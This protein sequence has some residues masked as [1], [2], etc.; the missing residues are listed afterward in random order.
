[1]SEPISF[2]YDAQFELDF[3][4]LGQGDNYAQLDHEFD[5]E[6]GKKKEH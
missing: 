4:P 3:F 6:N 2:T 5:G 1:M